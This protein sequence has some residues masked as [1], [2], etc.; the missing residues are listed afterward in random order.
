[1]NNTHLPQRRGA[2]KH[3]R[4]I[5]VLTYLWNGAWPLNTKGVDGAKAMAA[6]F[7]FLAYILHPVL[8]ST[9]KTVRAHRAWRAIEQ[10]QTVEITQYS[11][12]TEVFRGRGKWDAARIITVLLAVSYMASCGLELSMGLAYVE[13]DAD[14]LNR[15]PP[16]V[17]VAAAD[18]DDI[19]G[20]QVSQ[21]CR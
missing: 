14:M 8:T 4:E 9:F 12:V 18:S 16:V 7:I 5:M 21:H 1:M 19:D 15:P 17:L 6:S 2:A 11:T 13:G 3:P 10:H 20:W